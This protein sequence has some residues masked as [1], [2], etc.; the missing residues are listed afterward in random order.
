MALYGS[1]AFLV[2]F[3]GTITMLREYAPKDES[4]NISVVH[5]SNKQE[6]KS[7]VSNQVPK[8]DGKEESKAPDVAAPLATSTPVAGSGTLSTRQA[9]PIAIGGSSTGGTAASG[10]MMSVAPASSAPAVSSTPQPSG[11][12]GGTT[13]TT[14]PA[15]T[16]SQPIIAL[17]VVPNLQQTVNDLDG[18]TGLLP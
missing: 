16:T 9:S 1:A 14:Q 11:G 5:P 4:G 12:S 3:A 15:P 13:T 8:T 2:G 17:P 6:S 7:N 10:G 18:T